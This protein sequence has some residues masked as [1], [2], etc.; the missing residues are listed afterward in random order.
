MTC[1]Q[2]EGLSGFYSSNSYI[3]KSTKMVYYGHFADITLKTFAMSSKEPKKKVIVGLGKGYK[4]YKV[5]FTNFEKG[6]EPY[7][8]DKQKNIIQYIS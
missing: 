4:I 7:F 2:F 8:G 5:T 3:N 6:N 1:S